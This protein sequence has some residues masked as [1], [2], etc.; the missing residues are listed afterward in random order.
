MRCCG[1]DIQSAPEIS[2]GY[3]L[4][5]AIDAL[6]RSQY[7]LFDGFVAITPSVREEYLK[8]GIPEEKIRII[9]NGVSNARFQKDK[10]AR[11]AKKRASLGIADDELVIITVGRYHTKKGF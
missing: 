7:P 9:P 10:A 1:E 5:P 4:D 3:R 2:Y 8:M 11:R 6:A